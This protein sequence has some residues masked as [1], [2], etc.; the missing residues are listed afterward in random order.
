M[1]ALDGLLNAGDGAAQVGALE[2]SGHSNQ[3]LQVFAKDFVLRRQLLHLG[4]RAK[5]SNMAGGAEEDGVLDGI[6]AGAVGIVE[7]HADG[8]RPAIVDERF[9]RLDAVKDGRGV[10]GDFRSREAETRRKSGIDLKTGRG[11]AD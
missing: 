11:T 4:E 6:E 8:V 9:G 3:L 1:Q 5:R 2:A 10:G 7:A